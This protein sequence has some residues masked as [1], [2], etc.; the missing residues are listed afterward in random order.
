MF[1]GGVQP[2]VTEKAQRQGYEAAGFIVPSQE[3]ERNEHWPSGHLF[4]FT[5]L[6]SEDCTSWISVSHIQSGDSLLVY[7]SLEISKQI[8]PEVCLVGD[9]KSS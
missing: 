7:I 4:L 3:A 5:I 9:C 8:C 6:L 2:I 1:G